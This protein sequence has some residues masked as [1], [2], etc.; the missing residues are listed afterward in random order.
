[1]VEEKYQEIDGKML[2][3]DNYGGLKRLEN[4][5]SSFKLY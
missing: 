3:F 5:N 4:A 2:I 1:M